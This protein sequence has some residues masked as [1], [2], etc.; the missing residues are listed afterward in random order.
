M[1][2]IP[3]Y[4]CIICIPIFTYAQ[5]P[6][7]RD[8]GQEVIIDLTNLKRI[9]S[10][11]TT[12]SAR[13]I[14]LPMP[15]GELEIIEILEQ[16]NIDG[17]V[18][19]I[20]TY[21]GKS[22]KTNSNIKLTIS[23]YSFSVAIHYKG[24]YYFID[25]IDIK[26]NRFRLYN[27]TDVP[28]GRCGSGQTVRNVKTDVDNFVK[29]VG[30]FP[31]GTQ[32]RNFRMAAAATNEMVAAI[33]GGQ[34]AALVKI[35]EIMNAAN[36]IFEVEASIRFNL[37]AKTTNLTL[38][39]GYPFTIDPGFANA[40]NAQ[41]GFNA[42]STGILPYTEYDVGHVFNIIGGGCCSA[43]GQAGGTPCDN[44][45]KA[46]G[47]TEFTNGSETGFIA[48]L[49][50]HEV[51]HQFGAPHTYNANAPAF[52][53]GGWSETDAVEPG[54]GSTLMGYGGNCASPINYV[55]TAPNNENY[56]HTKSLEQIFATVNAV[57]C[58]VA[59]TTNNTP[60]VAN[61]GADFTIPKGTPFSLTGVGTDVNGNGTL[62]FVW[63]QYDNASANDRGAFG[64]SILGVGNYFAINSTESAPL[65][66]SRMSMTTPTRLFPSLQYILDGTNNPDDNIG[67]DLPQVGRNISFR[68]TVRDNALSG[69][70]LDSDDLEITVNGAA[71]PLALTSQ[72]TATTLTGGMSYTVS[73]SVNNTN[74]I[75]PNVKIS[76]S[77][78]GGVTFPTVLIASTLNDGT[79]SVLIPNAVEASTTARIKVSSTHATNH[80]FF[81]INNANLT[82]V[83]GMGGGC[84]AD[85]TVN[86]P[87]TTGNSLASNS[88]STSGTVAVSGAVVFSA[89]TIN[90][91][92]GFEVP[93]GNCFEANN[94]GCAYTGVLTC[95]GGGGAPT[96]ANYV[97]NTSQVI[98]D[99][100]DVVSTIM[101]A[102]AKTITEVEL[103]IT[104]N[105]EW[106]GDL[107]IK[108]KSPDNTEITVKIFNGS[109][110]CNGIFNITLDDDASVGPF[111]C[112][113]INP[114]TY[115]PST[116]LSGFDTKSSNGIWT[117]TV[118]DV[119]AED[120]GN[121]TSWGLRI[122]GT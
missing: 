74:T 94:V 111:V 121:L 81:D 35:T 18:N 38:I 101:V 20:K 115:R 70:G 21:N 118:R 51:G 55:L 26:K 52:C 73:W 72:N 97:N 6:G 61:A 27:M 109:L 105:H 15:S 63:D 29:S 41:D 88:I 78:D 17:Q 79:Q 92:A 54:S 56:F 13:Q 107:V 4:L 77:T 36:L 47:W 28:K 34:A 16:K 60:P 49:F 46:T 122:C 68:F 87:T 98:P 39:G 31:I 100:I 106:F 1:R 112:G 71:G 116:A 119:S 44:T 113:N 67:E 40:G 93:T 5:D 37:I 45:S 84:D 30:A 120:T 62:S 89:N 53:S 66:R 3:L 10:Q 64:G 33:Q 23:P 110:N 82:T 8:Y 19:E 69:G 95:E 25:P 83:T 99:L 65:F 12:K 85:V 57:T 86:G 14:T 90:L 58:Y 59:T 9:A 7:E 76:L 117:L 114:G 48:T 80:E 96:C 43:S 104:G 22:S 103:S 24:G 75:S 2:N 91:N 11:A 50:V 102:D 32:L 108:L 42:L